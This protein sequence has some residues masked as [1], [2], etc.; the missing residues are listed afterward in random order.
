MLTTPDYIVEVDWLKNQINNPDLIVLDATIPKVGST[1]KEI[2]KEC[3]PNALFFDI[4]NTFSDSKAEFPNTMLEPEEFELKARN[5]G[6]RSTSCIVVYDQHGI[7]SSPRVW[8]MFQTLG[9]ENIA[10]LNGG[11]PEWKKH[12]FDIQET[13]SI[14]KT[15]G[16]FVIQESRFGFVISSEV[17]KSINHSNK[18]I[19]DARS[20]A[21]FFGTSPEPRKEVRRGHIPS[22][23]SLP[24]SFVLNSN[25]LKPKEEISEIFGNINPDN[26]E[27]IFS[28]G[29]GITASVLAFAAILTNHSNSYVFDGSWT[30]WGSSLHLPIEI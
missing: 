18:L 2:S 14:A 19:L 10:V 6:I 17:L 13:F 22:S 20:Q 26:K 9:F 25:K 24:Y 3:I 21:R 29:S 5:L 7:Y 11:L 12:Q 28:C 30:E 16:D 1:K 15:K 4:K 8:F 23:K 27:M